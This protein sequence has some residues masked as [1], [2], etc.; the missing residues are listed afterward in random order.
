MSFIKNY[1]LFWKRDAVNFDLQ[2]EEEQKMQQEIAAYHDLHP[3]LLQTFPGQYVAVHGG[4]VVEHDHEQLAL[5]LRIRQHYPGEVVLI[6][7]VRPEAE[8]TWTMRVP[9]LSARTRFMPFKLVPRI[10]RMRLS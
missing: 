6:R 3:A 10:A 7:Q 8:K 1:G 9:K 5:Y 2:E 4:E